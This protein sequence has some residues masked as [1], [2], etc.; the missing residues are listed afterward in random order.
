MG[1]LP[2][3]RENEALHGAQMEYPHGAQREKKTRTVFGAP[4]VEERS[5]LKKTVFFLWDTQTGGTIGQ[6]S[7][8]ME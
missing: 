7:P 8:A 6:H 5:T 3:T 2:K 1:W 4:I